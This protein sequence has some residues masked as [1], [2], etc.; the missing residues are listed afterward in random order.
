VV[1]YQPVFV[2][3]CTLAHELGHAYHNLNLAHR[4][5]LQRTTPMTLA[6]T[7]STFCEVLV[8]QAGLQQAEPQERLTIL[9]AAL[10]VTLFAVVE[11]MSWFEFEQA[12]YAKRQQRPLSVDELS[13]LMWETQR[14]IY[15]DALDPQ[16]LH[17]LAW[18]GVPQLFWSSFYNFQYTFGLLFGLGL[19]AQYQAQP[20]AFRARYD[21]LLAS[22]GLA[23]AV[24]LAVPFAIDLRT[25]AFWRASLAVIRADIERFEGNYSAEKRARAGKFTV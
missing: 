5:V 15:G 16:A 20:A 1:N 18:A 8:Q 25:P 11:V 10:Q 2:E 12:L 14:R 4:T 22:T 23:E 17:P 7:A 6:E 9:D 21:E 3:V 19:Y 24:E 13:A